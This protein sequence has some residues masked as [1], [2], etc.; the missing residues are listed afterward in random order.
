[1]R[2]KT[3]VADH[4]IVTCV[5]NEGLRGAH[6]LGMPRVVDQPPIEGLFSATKPVQTVVRS[7]PL[8]NESGHGSAL[9]DPAL[10]SSP[11]LQGGIRPWGLFER[12]PEL[13]EEVGRNDCYRR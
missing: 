3:E 10:R 4:T 6:H 7:Q 5:P 13:I 1:M 8:R 9:V 2:G 11:P 12:S